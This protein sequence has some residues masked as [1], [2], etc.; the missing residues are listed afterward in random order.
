MG[1]LIAGA[2]TGGASS[3]VGIAGSLLASYLGSKEKDREQKRWEAKRA[4]MRLDRAEDRKDRE[5]ELSAQASIA[6][7]QQQTQ[8][9]HGSYTHDTAIWDALKGQDLS[10]GQKWVMTLVQAVKGL[11]RPLLTW[12]VVG[13]VVGIAATSLDAVPAQVMSDVASQAVGSLM[14]L[15]LMAWSWWFTDRQSSKRA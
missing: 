9:L 2:M 1:D 10:G 6:Q 13:A 14:H 11:T 7:A 12:V 4:Q 8:E 3:I 5:A 15:A